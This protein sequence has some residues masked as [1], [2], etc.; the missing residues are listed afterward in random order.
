MEAAPQ[1]KHG[2]QNEP[3]PV[4][5]ETILCEHFSREITIS[6]DGDVTTCCVDNRGLNRF[7]NIYE[8]SLEETMQRHR[9]TKRNF[10]HRPKKTPACL[11]C[12]R[13]WGVRPYMYRT[14]PR[15]HR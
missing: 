10:V 3:S 2:A 5:D 6:S 11:A 1:T 9:E 7:A 13:N 15:G 4:N 14:R 8:H 12:L